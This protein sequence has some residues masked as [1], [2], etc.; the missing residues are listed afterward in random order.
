MS[1]NRETLKKIYQMY[2][3]KQ[4]GENDFCIKCKEIASK[5]NHKL[6]N[7]PVPIYHVGNKFEESPK[8]LLFIGYVAYGWRDIMDLGGNVCENIEKRVEDLFFHKQGIG[9]EK[10]GRFW[11]YMREA[12]KELFGD[13]REGYRR[14][15]ISN[16]VRCNNGNIRDNILQ[17][18]ADYCCSKQYNG[19]IHK[20][21]EILQPTHLVILGNN[22]KY[23]RHLN[24]TFEK[25]KIKIL[26]HPSASVKGNSK[27]HFVNQVINFYNS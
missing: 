8:R 9:K 26:N 12:V 4:I 2:S 21:I 7:G 16:F 11:S 13:S 20:E 3:D 25:F 17:K 15:A 18:T 27:R 23:I 24:K 1:C 6:T 22:N 10:D 5:K 14:I 19:F